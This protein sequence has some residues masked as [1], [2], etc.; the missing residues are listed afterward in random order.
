M[1]A[2]VYPHRELFLL[3]SPRSQGFLANMLFLPVSAMPEVPEVERDTDIP[4]EADEA[5]F[6]GSLL[7]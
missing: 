3:V 7:A 6:S 2:P 5:E 4:V 1:E